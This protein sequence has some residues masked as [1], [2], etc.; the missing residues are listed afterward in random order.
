MMLLAQFSA[1][2]EVST[3]LH[4]LHTRSRERVKQQ[5]TAVVSLDLLR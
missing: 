4:E 1:I 5:D 2:L 3:L